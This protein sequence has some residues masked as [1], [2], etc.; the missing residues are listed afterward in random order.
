MDTAFIPPVD[1]LIPFLKGIALAG[2]KPTK[3]YAELAA[4]RLKAVRNGRRTFIR[5][6]EIERYIRSLEGVSEKEAVNDAG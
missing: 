3:G 1:P 5:A 4:G 6:S 2:L